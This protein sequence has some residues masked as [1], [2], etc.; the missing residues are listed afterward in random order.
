MEFLVRMEFALTSLPDEEVRRLTE[1]ESARAS[2]LAQAGVLCRV[3]RLPGRRANFGLWDAP[4]ATALHEALTSLPMWPFAE[5]E[6]W[7]LA[8]HSNDPATQ[9]SPGST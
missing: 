5:V 2:Q 4:D 3:W 1:A 6:V 8:R 7:P 9:S